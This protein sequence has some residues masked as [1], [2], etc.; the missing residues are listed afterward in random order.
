M[1]TSYQGT[2]SDQVIERSIG[3]LRHH[4]QK[5]DHLTEITAA[6]FEHRL[7]CTIKHKIKRRR[8]ECNGVKDAAARSRHKPAPPKEPAD[9]HSEGRHRR[10]GRAAG[11]GVAQTA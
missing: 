6:V 9:H 7:V 10:K 8:R 2:L 4:S 1:E 5:A 3:K 11:G